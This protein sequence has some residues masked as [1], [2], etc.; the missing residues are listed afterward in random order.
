MVQIAL[1]LVTEASQ[2]LLKE[3]IAQLLDPEDAELARTD[4]AKIWRETRELVLTHLTP[5]NS[6][7]YRSQRLQPLPPVE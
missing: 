3:R 5:G 1:P 2:Q 6:R 4:A 7:P